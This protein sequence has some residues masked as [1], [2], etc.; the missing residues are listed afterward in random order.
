MTTPVRQN[1]AMQQ[2]LVG[3]SDAMHVVLSDVESAARSD[4]KVLLTGETG[5]GKEVVARAVHQRSRRSAAPFI[6]I[7]CA[8]RTRCSNRSSSATRAAASPAP[9]ATI[10]VCCGKRTA[11]PCSSMKWAR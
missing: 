11:G 2:P 5:V 10:L 3:S 9:I 6:T 8:G 7:N 1:G 4:A